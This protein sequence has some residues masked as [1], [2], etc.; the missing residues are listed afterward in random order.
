VSSPSTVVVNPYWRSS[1]IGATIGALFN[2]TD[3]QANIDA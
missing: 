2:Y 3:W 1:I